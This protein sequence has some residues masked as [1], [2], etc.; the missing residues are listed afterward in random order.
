MPLWLQTD[1]HVSFVEINPKNVAVHWCVWRDFI[2]REHTLLT[3][4]CHQL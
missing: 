4:M 2:F 1:K 3:R